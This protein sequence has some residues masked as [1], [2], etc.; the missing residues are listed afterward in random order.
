MAPLGTALTP[1]QMRAAVAHGAE[2]PVLCF[3]GDRAGR[4][5]A[6]RAMETALPPLNPG[7]SLQFAFLT[8]APASTP[9]TSSASMA[10]A[11]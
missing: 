11:P 1:D 9:T 2:E 3:D 7:Y 6:Y 10:P 4:K 8:R 5:A